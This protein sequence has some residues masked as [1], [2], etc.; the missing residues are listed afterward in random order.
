MILF[1]TGASGFIG[2]HLVRQLSA[3]G[4]EIRALI[5]PHTAASM[6]K[7]MDLPRVQGVMGHLKDQAALNAACQG[8]DA[9][10]HLAAQVGTTDQEADFR[11]VNVE[12]TLNVLR[13]AHHAGIERVIVVSTAS[14]LGDVQVEL[15]D[16]LDP[17]RPANAYARSKVEA[18]RATWEFRRETGL[19]VVIIRPPW[20]YGPGDLRSIS[21]FRA[22]KARLPLPWRTYVRL[23]PVH[24]E[25]FT[26]GVRQCLDALPRV[27]GGTFHLAGP[28]PVPVAEIIETVADALGV[29]PPIHVSP[30][31]LDVAATACDALNRRVGLSLPL[32][33]RRLMFFTAGNAFSIRR[34][35]EAFAYTPAIELG[36]GLRR[37]LAWYR[38][39]GML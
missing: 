30:R 38:A 27:A 25:D 19:P 17:Y 15:A 32:T 16:E 36:D 3:R 20:V 24:V 7:R 10:V 8:A 6:V 2:H 23:H 4:D 18:E 22:V 12:G 33:R 21:L 5:R 35:Q 34:A 29:R 13:A 9:V 37:V 39:E 1:V 11:E 28:R 31:L 14:V 26:L